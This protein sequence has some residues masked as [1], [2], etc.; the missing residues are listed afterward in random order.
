MKGGEVLPGLIDNFI[1]NIAPIFIVV[2]VALIILIIIQRLVTKH[3]LAQVDEDITKEIKDKL[4][5]GFVIIKSI[6]VC[7]GIIA[8]LLSF[9]F[10]S[11]PFE[12]KNVET[13]TPAHIDE[14]YKPQNQK[15][16]EETNKQAVTKKSNEVNKQ[17]TE[18][19]TEAMDKAIDAFSKVKGH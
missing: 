12:N 15:Q 18:E 16:I 17:A 9:V 13:I 2:I 19:N 14:N 10:L 6:V 3:I 11:N 7:S 5:K 8:A 1:Y 4:N